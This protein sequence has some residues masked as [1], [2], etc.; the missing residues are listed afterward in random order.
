MEAL[1]TKLAE[2]WGPSGFEHQ[3]RD[4]IRAEVEPLADEVWVDALG[5]LICR[6]GE[7]PLRVMSAAHMDEIGVIVSHIDRQGFARFS[8]LGGVL[9]ASL[10]GARVRFENGTIAPV[11]V[12]HQFSKRNE[13]PRLE[14]F[15]LDLPADSGVRPG[16]PGAFVGEAQWQ[17]E[18]VIAKALDDRLGCAVQIEALRRLREQGT[19]HTLFFAFTVQE[20]IGRRGAQTGAFALEPDFG[21]AIDITPA[22]DAPKA[23]PS[24]ITLGGGAAIKVRDTR[25]IVPGW[26]RDLMVARAEETGIPYQLDVM[27]LGAT[28]G[29][30]IQLARAGVP[31]GGISIPARQV[32]TRSETALRG[33]IVAAVDLLVAVLANPIER[34]A[35]L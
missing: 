24:A 16:D 18:R 13:I 1:I 22:G 4:L 8:N 25:H 3:V 29:A 21:I 11:G 23:S 15:F 31:T 33:D 19:P 17:G 34:P 6:L 10:L 14:G 5:N 12:E 20:E 27:M 7:G 2:A 32:H 9:P 26:V 30:S 35:W 28:D